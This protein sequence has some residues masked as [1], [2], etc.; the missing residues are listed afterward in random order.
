MSSIIEWLDG[1]VKA[2]YGPKFAHCLEAVGAEDVS[3]LA[4]L[5]DEMIAQLEIRLQE[6]GALPIHL[7]RIRAAINALSETK[8]SPPEGPAP[9]AG[10]PLKIRLKRADKKYGCFISHHKASCAME[11]RHLMEKLEAQLGK[12]VFLDSDDLKVS[13]QRMA[14][15]VIQNNTSTPTITTNNHHQNHHINNVAGS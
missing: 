8:P 13:V 3:D 14:V 15:I 11:A 1:S 2:G 5:D 6:A 12:E 4:V 10:S 7:K 9:T